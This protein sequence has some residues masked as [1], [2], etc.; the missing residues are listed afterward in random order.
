MLEL[1]FDNQ[2]SLFKGKKIHVR[3]G[4]LDKVDSE[5]ES[6]CCLFQKHEMKRTH[7]IESSQN[8]YKPK[9]NTKE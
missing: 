6:C 9:E 1:L 8:A 4:T 5:E 7:S 2:F 3:L